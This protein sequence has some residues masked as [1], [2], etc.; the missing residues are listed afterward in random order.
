MTLQQEFFTVSE[1]AAKLG[2]SE[3]AV[4]HLTELEQLS[5]C[6][7]YKGEIDVIS[8]VGPDGTDYSH[9]ALGFKGVLRCMQPP[10][11]DQEINEWGVL[12]SVL[13]S[14]TLCLKTG[15]IYRLPTVDPLR[16]YLK[17]GHE[18][19]GFVEANVPREKWMFHIDDL[20]RIATIKPPAPVVVACD[21][22]T[23]RNRKLSWRTVAMP[24]MKL[25]FS[26]GKYK[27]ATVFYKLMLTRA[28]TQGSPFT[29]LN[30]ELFCKAAR[31]T[32]SQGSMGNV[33]AVIRA[34]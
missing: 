15:Q 28:D 12:V 34:H 10:T 17:P 4:I 25:V 3:D 5:I 21:T 2:L 33:W 32:V 23:K 22:P 24:Y 31:T 11:D 8:R 30:G 9:E 7:R 16:G 18:V 19:V 14:D 26:Q 13:R 6:F 1:T 27:S 29:K 20:A